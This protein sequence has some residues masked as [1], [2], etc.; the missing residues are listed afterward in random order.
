MTRTGSVTDLVLRNPSNCIRFDIASDGA[1]GT[2]VTWTLS[3]PTSMDD[4]AV[5]HRRHR[6]SSALDYTAV[7][8]CPSLGGLD[9]YFHSSDEQMVVD[10]RLLDQYLAASVSRSVTVR[11]CKGGLPRGAG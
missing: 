2:A 3:S 5:G 7:R 11:S 10:L 1:E 6:L 4:S 9:R 8:R